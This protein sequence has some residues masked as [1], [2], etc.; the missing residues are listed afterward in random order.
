MRPTRRASRT[1]SGWCSS[2]K[3]FLSRNVALVPGGVP[4]DEEARRE[5]NSRAWHATQK[6]SWALECLRYNESSENLAKTRP[7]RSAKKAGCRRE[8]HISVTSDEDHSGRRA[9]D[10]AIRDL[11]SVPHYLSNTEMALRLMVGTI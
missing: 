7:K 2:T 11:H 6:T 1:K 3:S 4:T 8:A 5:T 10:T 9:I